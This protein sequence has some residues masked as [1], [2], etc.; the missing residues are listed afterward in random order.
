MKRAAFLVL[1]LLLSM[2]LVMAQASIHIIEGTY[3]YHAPEDMTPSRAKEEALNRAKIEALA[4]T[5]GTV[6]SQ[7]SVSVT[8]S[9]GDAF[10]S[11]GTTHVKGE[12]L[13][14]LG[15]PRFEM[16]FSE[17][18]MWVRCTVRGK[19]RE[20]SSAREDVVMRI[21]AN[22]IESYNESVFLKAGS[23]LY[24]SQQAPVDGYVAIF[25][26]DNEN[27]VVN[28]LFPY[29][30]SIPLPHKMQ[31]NRVNYFFDP[32]NDATGLKVRRI[33]VDCKK[34]REINTIY[35][36]FSRSEYPMPVLEDHSADKTMTPTLSYE[37]FNKWISKRQ[38]VDSGFQVI[39]ESITISKN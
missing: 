34:P 17:L 26:Y 18:G 19:A 2:P 15:E 1:L 22:G 3:L 38:I 35:L 28:C 14:T 21:Y 37:Q 36:T 25:L 32:Q 13:E 8:S 27:D 9:R 10:Y 4:E 29:K 20:I 23:H 30:G 5:F 31:A 39:K 11:E 6:V 7:S 24:V 16:G 12:W 33:T